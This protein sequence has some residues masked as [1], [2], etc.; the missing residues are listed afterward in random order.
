MFLQTA[1]TIEFEQNIGKN[2]K[3]FLDIR[4]L[5]GKA[6]A[7]LQL[8]AEPDTNYLILAE[9][10]TCKINLASQLVIGSKQGVACS[11]RAETD[12]CEIE[13]GSAAQVYILHYL[14]IDPPDM[15]KVADGPE[16]CGVVVLDSEADNLFPLLKVLLEE[17]Q[18]QERNYQ[19]ICDAITEIVLIQIVRLTSVKKREIRG[20]EPAL[21]IKSYIDENYMQKITLQS[22]AKALFLSESTVSHSFTSAYDMTVGKYRMMMRIEQSKQLLEQKHQQK[23][24][25]ISEIACRVGFGSLT[26]YYRRFN[27]AVGVSPAAYR[28]S[29]P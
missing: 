9:Q 23:H 20:T 10:G 29:L 16:C 26:T 11:I 1:T 21:A 2:R 12:H 24:L 8:S 3:R 19:Y 13:F 25:S 7:R 22:I 17:S 27:S 5:T 15:A 18:H 4:L 14:E 6:G 28:E